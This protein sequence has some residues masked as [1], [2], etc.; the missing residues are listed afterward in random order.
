MHHYQVGIDRT[1]TTMSVT[2]HLAHPVQRLRAREND[3]A[4]GLRKP[5]T[6]SDNEKRSRRLSVARR[7]LRVGSDKVRCI[8]YEYAL[9]SAPASNERWG[10]LA[11]T[12]VMISPAS[13]LWLPAGDDTRVQVSFDLPQNMQVSVPWTPVPGTKQP[14]FEFGESP[15]SG[16]AISAFGYFDY[17]EVSAHRTTLRVAILEGEH[18]A[19]E[20]VVMGWLTA[21]VGNLARTY[22]HFPN[23]SPQVVVMPVPPRAPDK[24]PVPFGHV[25]RDGGEG[26]RFFIDPSKSLAQYNADWTATHE[27]AH[28]MLPYV[29]NRYKWISE[30]FASYYQNVLM[31][32]AGEYSE[33]YAWQKLHNGFRGARK[34]GSHISPNDV[35]NADFG[36][37]RMMI[38]WSGAAFALL[39]DYQLRVQSGGKQ[40]LG[41]VLRELQK[42]CLPSSRTWTAMELFGRLDQMS[43]TTVFT[44]LYRE[45]ADT[46]GMP[47]MRAAYKRLGIVT[48][49]RRVSLNDQAPD[50]DVRQ[51]IMSTVAP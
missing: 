41:T 12:N 13:W 37:A 9:R 23:P 50:A 40:T 29:G 24:S 47:D 28:L 6:C 7:T 21:S 38:Y 42:C 32:R 31:A 8:Q 36:T 22:G 44:G 33:Q 51:A 26:I 35:A 17:R 46:K 39:A 27:F 34:S 3:A 25:I 20:Q 14:T 15:R 2:V 16:Q 5:R 43:S 4:N 30:G 10:R 45:H 49:G 48:N 18:Q 1:L 11:D 19:D